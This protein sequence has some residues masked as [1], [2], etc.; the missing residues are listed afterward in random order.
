[1]S[2]EQQEQG[3]PEFTYRL[4]SDNLPTGDWIYHCA[5]RIPLVEYELWNKTK[6]KITFTLTSEIS[7]YSEEQINSPTL[8]P[9]EHVIFRQLPLLIGNKVRHLKE[10][11]PARVSICISNSQDEKLHPENSRI[12]LMSYDTILWDMQDL[13]KKGER[14]YLLKHIVAWIDAHDELVEEQWLLAF[15][16]LKD[17][18]YL[19]YP[20]PE[21]FDSAIPKMVVEAIFTTLRNNEKLQYDAATF[22]VEKLSKDE[23][24]QSIQRSGET[25]KRTLGNCIDGAV[26]YASIMLRA[27]LDPVIVI[28]QGHAFVGWRTWNDTLWRKFSADKKYD[29]LETRWTSKQSGR[30]FEQACEEGNKLYKEILAKKWLKRRPFHHLGFASRLDIRDLRTRLGRE[31]RMLYYLEKVVDEPRNDQQNAATNNITQLLSVVTVD[32]TAQ[33]S[34]LLVASRYIIQVEQSLAEIRSEI[35]DHMTP[36]ECDFAIGKLDLI[37]RPDL[38]GEKNTFSKESTRA[39]QLRQLNESVKELKTCIESLWSRYTLPDPAFEDPFMA[40]RSLPEPDIP[41]LYTDLV[42]QTDTIT[43]EMKT[44]L[45]KDL[46]QCTAKLAEERKASRMPEETGATKAEAT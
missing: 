2:K 28:Q 42:Q 14:I 31:E 7:G 34:H 16:F 4:L 15:N 32:H 17:H 36:E 33:Q 27:G 43:G 25:L 11:T 13:S 35:S 3:K 40:Q 38:S 26:L 29:F 20:Y 46:L 22:Q 19:G 45:Y 9:G 18:D 6:E 10:N 37:R 23:N 5:K 1:M 8:E 44:A 41:L 24:S 21:A 30:T 39:S 12:K